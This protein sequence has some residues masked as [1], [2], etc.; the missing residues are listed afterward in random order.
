MTIKNYTS[1]VPAS[2]SVTKIEQALVELGAERI[3][4]GYKNG[5][6]ESISFSIK[7]G[8]NI[9]PFMLPAQVEA[10]ETIFSN[11]RRRRPTE[12]QRKEDRQQA[13]RTAWKLIYEWILKELF[14]L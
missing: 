3:H 8:E 4:K 5:V 14:H 13:E 9:I 6:L 11:Q 2:L 10:I 1:T 7:I 12:T